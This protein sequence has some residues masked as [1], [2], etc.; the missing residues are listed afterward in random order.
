VSLDGARVYVTTRG[1]HSLVSLDPI[2]RQITSRLEVGK[3]P[4]AIAVTHA[5]PAPDSTPAPTSLPAAHPT[6]T[7]TIVPAPTPLPDG[8]LPPEHL[9]N[10][11]VSEP[12]VPGAAYPVTFAFAPDGTLFYNELHTGNIRVVK[13][14]ELLA[15]AFYNFKVSGQ[16]EAGLIGL[17]LDPDFAKNHYVYVFYTSVPEGQ[18]NGGPNGP[19]ELVRLTDVADKGTDLTSILRDLPSA[20]IHNSGTLRFGPEGKLYVS[21]GDNDQGSNAQDLGTL[22]GKILRVNPDG[23]IPG[24]NPFVGQEASNRPSGP[25]ACAI[26]SALTSTR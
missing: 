24:D 20:P 16:P 8:V 5:R 2:R 6:A 3:D 19:N 25:T 15:D 7:P 22:A 23:S 18:E 17:T 11:V 10:G 9:P 21:L 12:F 26:C 1:D 13:N 4:V 14:G